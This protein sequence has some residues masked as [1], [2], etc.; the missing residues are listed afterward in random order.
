M[1]TWTVTERSRY[2]SDGFGFDFPHSRIP[3]EFANER[4]ALQYAQRRAESADRRALAANEFLIEAN[5]V[6]RHGDEP[7]HEFT[8]Q[9]VREDD[10]GVVA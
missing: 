9:P 7:V 4:L 1:S 3:R 2:A 6:V 10:E 5:I 8:V